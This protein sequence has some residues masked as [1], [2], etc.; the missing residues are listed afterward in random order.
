MANDSFTGFCI[1][2][3]LHSQTKDVPSPLNFTCNVVSAVVDNILYYPSNMTIVVDNYYGSLLLANTLLTKHVYLVATVRSN[4]KEV[5]ENIETIRVSGLSCQLIDDILHLPY[6]FKE[7]PNNIKLFQCNDINTFQMISSNLSSCLN[8]Q[9]TM[10]HESNV[11]V[12]QRQNYR[13][14]DSHFRVK[15]RLPCVA[16]FYNLFMGGTDRFDQMLATCDFRRRCNRWIVAFHYSAFHIA[17]TNAWIT[18][19]TKMKELNEE[20]IKHNDFIEKLA[21]ELLN[22]ESEANSSYTNNAS[23]SR[24]TR[25]NTPLLYDNTTDWLPLLLGKTEKLPVNL[26][27]PQISQPIHLTELKFHYPA[28]IQSPAVHNRL[29]NGKLD[30]KW[31]PN[32]VKAGCTTS[33]NKCCRVCH[34]RRCVSHFGES[35]FGFEMASFLRSIN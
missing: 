24:E 10:I 34:V 15:K 33:T 4:R 12:T 17:V 32:C 16:R 30:H 2:F 19:R 25:I 28:T 8:N 13:L 5:A 14:D 1:F 35:H 18:Y 21:L 31:R 6:K 29:P 11:S 9:L 3:K 23:R 26:R 20:A 7:F 22:Y 27:T